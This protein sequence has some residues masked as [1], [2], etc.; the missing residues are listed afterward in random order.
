MIKVE[1]Y[2]AFCGVMRISPKA[3]NIYLMNTEGD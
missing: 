1:G 2:K 3:S